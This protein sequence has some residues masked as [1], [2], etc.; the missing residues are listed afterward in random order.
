M[1]VDVAVL[2]RWMNARKL[3]AELV[4]SRAELD[5]SVLVFPESIDVVTLP[6]E[7]VARL[8]DVLGID[9]S[10]LTAAS[11]A[12]NV[13]VQS[14]EEFAA[15]CRGIHRDG[16]HFYN[17]YSLPGP[18]GDV[19]GVILDILCEAD[20]LPVLNNGHREPAITVNLGPGDI[21]A[22]W[23]DDPEA[24]FASAVLEANQG[25]SHQWVVGDSY[26]ESTYCPHSYALAS[27][28]PARIISYTAPADLDSLLDDVSRHGPTEFDELNAVATAGTVGLLEAQLRL[29]GTEPT[30]E[31]LAAIT[32][33]IADDDLDRLREFARALQVDY[34]TL[35]PADS[36]LD[37]L[38]KRQLSYRESIASRR[39]FG[40]YEVASIAGSN[41]L[42]NLAGFYLNVEPS[43][44]CSNDL[45]QA[46]STT[47]FVTAGEVEVTW[48]EEGQERRAPLDADGA[49]WVAPF[50]RHGFS[51]SGHVVA[52]SSGRHLVDTD[53]LLLSRMYEA[54]GVL[55]R[56]AGDRENWGYEP[57][58]ALATSGEAR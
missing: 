2:N 10:V 16:I 32:A 18:P 9:P 5:P 33:A 24:P 28:R 57:A 7:Q 35:L 40:R 38:G 49:V 6:I 23:A 45:C 53:A 3:T 1:Q 31:L 55:R 42:P 36:D 43:S 17:Y 8:A 39:R 11:T 20:R 4:A 12:Q 13:V 46:L 15:T 41:A 26:V 56:S 29:R 44:D 48:V 27:E 19:G 25:S 58:P 37:P 14:S 22:R 21:F 51:G 47:Y 34:R 54:P 30:P 52:L 50:V